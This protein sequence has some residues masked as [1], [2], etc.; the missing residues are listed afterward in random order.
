MI[1]DS[2]LVCS[3]DLRIPHTA[4]KHNVFVYYHTSLGGNYKYKHLPMGLAGSPDIFQEK[5][6]DLMHGLDFVQCY[7]DDVL[8]I[9]TRTFEEPS[10]SGEVLSVYFKKA[11]LKR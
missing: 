2:I 11:G 9:S 1:Q 10:Q 3:P 5:M 8:I 6:S 7:L 4:Q